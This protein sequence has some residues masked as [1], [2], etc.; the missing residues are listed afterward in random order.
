MTRAR[1]Y[2]RLVELQELAGGSFEELL[3]AV[4]L[5]ERPAYYGPDMDFEAVID[6]GDVWYEFPYDEEG[7]KK[8]Q[9]RSR[10]PHLTLYA[11]YEG[12]K[13]P[14]VHWRTTIGSWRSEIHEGEEWFAY[15]NS[16]VGP[17]V[18]KDIMAA[19]AWIPPDYTPTRT[20]TKK[21]SVNGRWK[22]VVNYDETGPGYQSAYGLVAAY[23]IKQ[24][25]RAD[26]TIRAELDNQI[27]THGSVDYMSIMR[28][29]SHGCH[30]LYN[31]NAVRMFSFILQHR[32]LLA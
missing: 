16:D 4:K 15:K 12:Q 21:K 2:E 29:Y 9:P 23:H 7:N 11:N 22:R 5:P 3:V 8:G 24:V 25:K 30:R 19:P 14:L 20:L 17:R 13:I 18:W 31:M 28:R 1:A 6:R 10:Y 32:N 27:R 26:G